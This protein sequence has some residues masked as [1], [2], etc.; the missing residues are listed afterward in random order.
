M[1]VINA[2]QFGTKNKTL[3][4]KSRFVSCYVSAEKLHNTTFSDI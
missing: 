1:S 2:I 4:L 3:S